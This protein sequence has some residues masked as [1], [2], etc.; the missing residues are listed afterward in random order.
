VLIPEGRLRLPCETRP[1]L[2]RGPASPFRDDRQ[3][4]PQS[5]SPA[6]C[7]R[8]R[9]VWRR[10]RAQA[11]IRAADAF[12][13]HA[14]APVAGAGP[15]SEPIAIS[16]LKGIDRVR[17]HLMDNTER[18]AGGLPANNLLLWGARGMGKSACA[19]RCTRDKR[20]GPR[21]LVRSRSTART[22]RS[23]RLYWHRL[24]LTK[25]R[26]ILFLPPIFPRRRTPVYKSTEGRC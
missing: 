6:H 5:H 21:S 7:R 18:F 13:W 8:T 4:E 22:F 10:R 12:V 16:L 26:C 9:T 25:R 20:S 14:E 17:R 3:T 19:R 24:R 23:L 15:D 1:D 11:R 2:Y